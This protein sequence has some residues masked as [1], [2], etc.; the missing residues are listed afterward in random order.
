MARR[1]RNLAALRGGQN[2]L[3]GIK[4]IKSISLFKDRKTSCEL[5]VIKGVLHARRNETPLINV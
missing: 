2:L 4:V 3:G 5:V 1:W